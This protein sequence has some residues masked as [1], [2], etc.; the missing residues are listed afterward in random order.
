MSRFR[1]RS[2]DVPADA[3][4]YW[5][6]DQWQID[7]FGYR[8]DYPAQNYLNH[9]L[10][11]SSS[12]CYDKVAWSEMTDDSNRK[13]GQP[14]KSCTHLKCD[15]ACFQA[16]L[17]SGKLW[18]F[19]DSDLTSHFLHTSPKGDVWVY[20]YK[21]LWYSTINSKVVSAD[22]NSEVIALANAVR[23]LVDSKAL[24][25]VTFK[26]LPQAVGMVLNPFR[27]LVPDWRRR[28]GRSPAAHLAKRGANIWLEGQYGWK[29]AYIDLCN[30]AKAT[31]KFIS[32]T[33][34]FSR[35]TS[36]SYRQRSDTYFDG[37]PPTTSDADWSALVTSAKNG[38]SFSIPPTRIVF[39]R[40]RART[41]VSCVCTDALERQISQIHKFLYAYGLSYEQIIS[42]I[43]EAL[44]YSFVVDWIVNINCTA[45]ASQFQNAA[46]TLRDGS[47]SKLGYSVKSE[48]TY[49]AETIAS[50]YKSG[51]GYYW[52]QRNR[53]ITDSEPVRSTVGRCSVYQRNAGMPPFATPSFWAG[54]GLLVSQGI[55]GL[56]L[57]FQRAVKR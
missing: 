21:D 49:H 36:E 14:F 10:G 50:S 23:G 22:W 5:T 2:V 3:N 45:Q 8:Y 33:A 26:E 18:S 11:S 46:K 15:S 40:G 55:S 52:T 13:A 54:K 43:W 25:A 38:V 24:L 34:R 44:P 31:D 19:V 48:L 20:P 27:L 12:L 29:A 47:V 57:I 6:A 9:Y 7:K 28:A 39:D 4:F 16:S 1:S 41:V 30:F 37:P 35:A 42:S 17:I 32:S 51:F 56:S 53:P